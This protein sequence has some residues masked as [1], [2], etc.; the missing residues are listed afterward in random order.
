MRLKDA[1][2]SM[3]HQHLRALSEKEKSLR[4]GKAYWEKCLEQMKREKT[5]KEGLCQIMIEFHTDE[6][7]KVEEMKEKAQQVSSDFFQQIAV[8]NIANSEVQN[9]NS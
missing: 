4:D 9:G 7:N 2:R 6:L 5:G 1:A 8:L 3:I